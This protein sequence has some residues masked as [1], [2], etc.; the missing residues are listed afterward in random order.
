MEDHKFRYEHSKII[1]IDRDR[2]IGG[3]LLVDGIERERPDIDAGGDL[4]IV[5]VGVTDP[6]LHEIAVHQFE[7]V[8]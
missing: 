5:A 6:E 3:K 4:G 8:R 7:H 1:G 2:G